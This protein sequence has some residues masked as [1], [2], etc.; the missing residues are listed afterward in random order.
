MKETDLNLK[1]ILVVVG[2]MVYVVPTWADDYS[3]NWR[4]LWQTSPSFSSPKAAFDNVLLRLNNTYGTGSCTADHPIQPTDW[5]TANGGF[6]ILVHC[7]INKVNHDYDSYNGGTGFIMPLTPATCASGGTLVTGSSPPKCSGLKPPASPSSSGEWIP[8]LAFGT[9]SG[10][11]ITYSKQEG[12]YSV[13]ADGKTV[14]YTFDIV[15]TNKGTGTGNA[16][17]TGLPFPD[18]TSMVRAAS[19]GALTGSWNVNTAGTPVLVVDTGVM[20]LWQWESGVLYNITNTTFGACSTSSPCHFRG[21][22]TYRKQ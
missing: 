19:P 7:T 4:N 13:G 20:Y 10:S 22:G 9:S 16:T 5:D 6:Y 18:D 14:D 21:G 15:V 12:T 11:D 17:M 3:N 2:M 8:V 1:R